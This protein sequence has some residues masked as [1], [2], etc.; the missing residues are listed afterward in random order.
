MSKILATIE[1]HQ[2]KFQHEFNV[3][4]IPESRRVKAVFESCQR[5]LGKCYQRNFITDQ[6]IIIWN[7]QNKKLITQSNI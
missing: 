4:N 2:N 3:K 1:I 6:K 5:H 7:F